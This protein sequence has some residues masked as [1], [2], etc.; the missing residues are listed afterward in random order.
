MRLNRNHIEIK[1]FDFDVPHDDITGLLE[2]KPTHF[3]IKPDKYLVGPANGRTEKNRNTNYWGFVIKTE[4]NDWIGDLANSFLV[5]IVVPRKRAIKELTDKYHGV[6]SV[7]Q[8]MH[9]GCNPGLYFDKAQIQIL[10]ESGLELD[11]DI[12]VLSETETK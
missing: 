3:W 6:F 4:T 1:F 11:I 8:Y 7:V 10:N 9:E 5:E 2:L 12:Y